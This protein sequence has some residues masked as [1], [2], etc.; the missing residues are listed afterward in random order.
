MLIRV[1]GEMSKSFA[2]PNIMLQ[3]AFTGIWTYLFGSFVLWK[4]EYRREFYFYV[5]KQTFLYLFYAKCY[6]F[7]DTTLLTMAFH[8]AMFAKALW[9]LNNLSFQMERLLLTTEHGLSE[10]IALS[11]VDNLRESV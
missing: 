8:A 11:L 4:T 6:P 3:I 9:F 10:V 2:E 5:M 1:V 7:V